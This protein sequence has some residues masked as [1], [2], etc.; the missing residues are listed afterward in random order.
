MCRQKDRLVADEF[1]NDGDEEDVHV[2]LDE[3]ALAEKKRDSLLNTDERS[4]ELEESQQEG[5][6]MCE[7][8]SCREYGTTFKFPSG[9]AKHDK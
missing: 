2:E 1:S 6:Y 7:K 9:K 8:P 5:V 4:E 3:D